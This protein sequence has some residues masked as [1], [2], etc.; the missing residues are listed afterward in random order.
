MKPKQLNV[1]DT[2]SKHTC[3]QLLCRTST[4]AQNDI[5][6]HAQI[7]LYAIHYWCHSSCSHSH[8]IVVTYRDTVVL[9]GY[10]TPNYCSRIKVDDEIVPPVV[11]QV[12]LA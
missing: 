9:R 1:F 10:G 11:W 8:T 12:W 2:I 3:L 5:S 7:L 4:V 6:L